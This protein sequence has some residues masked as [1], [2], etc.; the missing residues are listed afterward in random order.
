MLY[1]VGQLGEHAVGNIAGTL[2]HEVHADAPGADQLDRLLDLLKQHL[3]RIPEQ[4]MGLVKE[5]HQLGLIQIAGFRQALEQLREHPQQETGVQRGVLYQLDAVQHIDHAASLGVGTHP[6]LNLQ[7]RFTEEQL[8]ALLLQR[9]QRP[10]DGSHRL[11]CDVAVGHHILGAVL[12]NVGQH[13]PQ[14][15]QIDQQQAL[16]VRDA[17]HNMQDAL[18]GRGQSK[19]TGQQLRPHF[20]DGG[21]D[22]VTALL[23]NIPESGGIA[24]IGED[25]PQ[26]EFVNALLHPLAALTGG[27]DTG[28]IALDVAQEHR[29]ACVRKGFRHHLHGD[30][31]S[32]TAGTGDQAVTVAHVQA[33]FHPLIVRQT[34]VDLAVFVHKAI[35]RCLLIFPDRI[36]R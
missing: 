16:I 33:H 18:L 1:T 20:A 25:I 34:H 5:E 4:H 31:L 30:G 28:H 13:G 17:E 14:V 24:A 6:V 12:V 10:E 11:G 36:I 29:H 32:R 35:L 22:G 2:G 23:I 8:P 9:Q 15:F 3:G 21:A 26:A 19:N 27:A 7:R